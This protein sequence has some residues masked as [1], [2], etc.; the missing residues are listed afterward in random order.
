[1]LT[2]S[3]KTASFNVLRNEIKLLQIDAGAVLFVPDHNW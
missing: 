3:N 2:G 1:M